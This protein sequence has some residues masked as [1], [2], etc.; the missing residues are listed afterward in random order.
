[1]RD[2]RQKPPSWRMPSGGECAEAWGRV[3]QPLSTAVQKAGE[4]KQR[5]ALPRIEPRVGEKI[6]Q[7]RQWTDSAS[8]MALVLAQDLDIDVARDV[9]LATGGRS[10][11]AQSV[12]VPHADGAASATVEHANVQ[13]KDISA[14]RRRKAMGAVGL[15]RVVLDTQT[16]TGH[17]PFHA[18]SNAPNLW[19]QPGGRAEQSLSY[20]NTTAAGRHQ[21]ITKKSGRAMKAPQ[22]ACETIIAPKMHAQ[23]RRLDS[24]WRSFSMLWLLPGQGTADA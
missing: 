9:E 5:M 18:V 14:F 15:K 4:A 11:R 24:L 10:R 22:P 20:G 1:M 21:I 13:R 7:A 2:M 12:S 23:K 16:S 6:L 3:T 17:A 8:E 19:Q